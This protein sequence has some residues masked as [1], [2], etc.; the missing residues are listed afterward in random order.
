MSAIATFPQHVTMTADICGGQPC[1]AGTRI[2]IQDLVRRSRA[3]DTPYDI[4]I[5]YPHLSLAKIYSAL[6]FYHDNQAMI[7]EL[8]SHSDAK[9]AAFV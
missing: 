9:V 8:I 6:A 1:I 7:D 4:L 3:G 2:R 5:A